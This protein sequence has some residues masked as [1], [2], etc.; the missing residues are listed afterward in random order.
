[1]KIR[2]SRCTNGVVDSGG[3]WKKSSVR[4]V[5]IIDIGG[6]FATIIN[7]TSIIGGKICRQ[8]CRYRWQICYRCGVFDTGGAP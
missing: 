4:K 5:L 6:K 2:S 3:K 7:N 8:Y 1:M